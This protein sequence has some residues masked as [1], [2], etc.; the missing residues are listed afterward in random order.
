MAIIVVE[1]QI[2]EVG[3]CCLF[4]ANTMDRSLLRRVFLSNEKVKALL[5]KT[6]HLFFLLQSTN[7][8][9]MVGDITD[10]LKP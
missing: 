4:K 2:P 8:N 1:V 6:F 3:A 5:S 7:V 9:N 10:I